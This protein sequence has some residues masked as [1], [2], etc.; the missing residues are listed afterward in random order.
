[1]ASNKHKQLAS[2]SSED[3]SAEEQPKVDHPKN[4][5]KTVEKPNTD[6]KVDTKKHK[7]DNKKK[8][9]KKL[10]KKEEPKKKSNSSDSDSEEV[11]KPKET[12]KPEIKK[13]VPAETKKQ[14]KKKE[15]KEESSSDDESDDA[16]EEEEKGTKK[17][18]KK[19]E[20]K[21]EKKVAKKEEKEKQE[22]SSS[23]EESEE[24]NGKSKGK[25]QNDLK[26]KE[27]KPKE[28]GNSAA[29]S[30]SG[31]RVYVG[32][33]SFKIDDDTIKAFFKDCGEIKEI[34]WVN[35][36]EGRFTGTGFLEFG[37]SEA[38]QDALK[39]NGEE[40]ME[41]KIKVELAKPRV[42]RGGRGGGGGKGGDFE[43]SPKP[44]GCITIFVGK[45]SYEI[46]EKTLR[47]AFKSCGEI[48]EIR[49]LNDRESGQF[50]GCGFVEFNSPDAVDKAVK[51]NGTSVMGRAMKIDYASNKRN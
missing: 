23:E 17:E 34:D 24:E 33:L 1:M 9:D 13:T 48:K 16:A 46:D 32:N 25:P 35:N 47:D 30:A 6:E 45:L 10:P 51:L 28:N 20:K 43:L 19:E 49:W 2:D 42:D 44:D 3:S 14:D 50:K 12:K 15:P 8:E 40:C 18:E 38:A 22:S 31:T 36:K 4:K 37:N 26:K 21:V 27:Q 7:P 41:R 29:T 39:K 11:K 5:R